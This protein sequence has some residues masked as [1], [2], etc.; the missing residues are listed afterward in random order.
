VFDGKHPLSGVDCG[1]T[2]KPE[3]GERKS[4]FPDTIQHIKSF[5]L[6]Q[7]IVD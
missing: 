3:L 1:R 6:N 7:V 2:D 4:C 5:N